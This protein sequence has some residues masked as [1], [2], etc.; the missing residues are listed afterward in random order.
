M[1]QG[2]EPEDCTV[3]PKSNLA[4]VM[5]LTSLKFITAKSNRADFAVEDLQLQ[6][7]AHAPGVYRLRCGESNSLEEKPAGKGR[8]PAAEMLLARPEAVGELAVSSIVREGW[9]G[10]RLEQG[11][12]ALE[13]SSSPL[14]F[15]L[16]KGEHCVLRSEAEATLAHEASEGSCLWQLSLELDCDEALCGLGETSGDL[17]RRG[18]YLVSDLPGMRMLPLAWSPRGWGLYVNTVGRV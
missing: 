11:E 8:V 9:Q 16:Y 3:P 14:Q 5:P 6:I 10:W 17:D 7:E 18:E 13:V 2:L 12:I 15:S 4:H 1:R